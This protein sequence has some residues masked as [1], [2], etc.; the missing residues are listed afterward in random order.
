MARP[1]DPSKWFGQNV[2]LG[3][4][5]NTSLA[6]S[7]SYSGS[8][9]DIPITIWRGKQEGPTVSVT[10]AVHGDEINGT[11]V[12][13]RLIRER[14]FE[15]RAGTLVLLPVIN[16]LG[17]ERNTRYMPDRR[18]LNRSFPGTLHGSTTSRMAHVIFEKV[19]TR[20]D[21]GIDLHSAAIRRT[22]FPNVRADMSHEKLAPFARAFGAELIVNKKGPRGSLRNS[23]CQHGCATLILEAGEIWKVESGVVEYALRGIINCLRFLKM[24]EGKPEEPP[25]RVEVDLTRWVRAV[26]GGFL[27][28]HVSPG[29]IVDKDQAL[30]TNTDLTGD[31]QNIIRAPRDAFVL[32]M[33]TI[34]SVA[35]GDAVCH[36]AYPRQGVTRRISR[37]VDKLGENTLHERMREDLA[38]NVHLRPAE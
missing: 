38:S 6:I 8:S 20:C 2:P 27:E 16:I 14:L 17:F 1:P 12:I 21:Y 33:T 28:F 26:Q 31:E 15:L 24:V 32:G 11:G 10:A 4:C 34:P 18:D 5:V 35:P 13:R 30:A 9:V 7:E 25:Y 36:L 22:N 23:A 3:T 29:D 37:L 19:I